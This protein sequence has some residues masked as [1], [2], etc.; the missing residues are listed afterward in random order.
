MI[1]DQGIREIRELAGGRHRVI[2]TDG[3]FV[4]APFYSF[5]EQPVL[6]LR[7]SRNGQ[8]K[9][10]RTTASHRWFIRHRGGGTEKRTTDQLS[11]SDR[12]AHVFPPAIE[13]R[14]GGHALA[15]SP[16]GIARGIVFGDGTLLDHGSI[17]LLHRPTCRRSPSRCPTSSAGWPATSPPTVTS[18]RTAAS[19]CTRPGASIWSSCATSAPASASAPT[20]SVKIVRTRRSPVT[21]STSWVADLP[22]DFFL[23]SAHR[24]RFVGARRKYERRG[25]VVEA[26]RGPRRGDGGLLPGGRGHPRVRPGG[27][28]PHRQLP[29]LRAGRRRD[30]VPDGRGAPVVRRVA[31]AAGVAAGLQLRYEESTTPRTRPGGRRP[32]SGSGCCSRTPRPPSS[33]ATSS[34]RPARARPASSSPSAVSAG[35]PPSGTAAASPPTPGTRSPSTCCR[36]ASPPRS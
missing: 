23:I 27:Q 35:T 28:H 4:E 21:G 12:L 31:G 29:R 2:T 14:D 36:R 13:A 24:D 10:I 17:A 9:T 18:R 8:Q 19:R 32:G 11:R 25:W 6:H 33:T 5:G 16:F 3:R 15:P 20:A 1:T 34:A 26:D 7:L 30:Q 22:E